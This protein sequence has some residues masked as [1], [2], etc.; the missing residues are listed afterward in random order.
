MA[1]GVASVKSELLNNTPKY[2]K[3]QGIKPGNKI[4][5]KNIQ[6]YSKTPKHCAVRINLVGS[7]AKVCTISHDNDKTS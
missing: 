4:W 3:T 5:R 2:N 1:I 7:I 6:Y